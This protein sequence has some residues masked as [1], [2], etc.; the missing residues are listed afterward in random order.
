MSSC[1]RGPAHLLEISSEDS[2]CGKV[3]SVGDGKD[4]KTKDGKDIK[5]ADMTLA[6]DSGAKFDVAVWEDPAI[7]KMAVIP[8]GAGVSLIGCTATRDA[9]DGGF[10]INV[11]KTV[12][13]ITGGDRADALTQMSQSEV[14]GC[15]SLTASS[16]G[17]APTIDMT[18]KEAV[19]VSATALASVP[20][21]GQDFPPDLF[22]QLNRQSVTAP[23]S[24][25]LIVT[26]S[27]DRLWVP[28][29]VSDWT[30]SAS[31][32][33]GN[34]S[35]PTLYDC[36]T[37]DEVHEKAAKGILEVTKSRLNLRGAIRFQDGGV[38]KIVV[39][40]KKSSLTSQISSTSMRMTKGVSQILAEAAQVAPAD[41][42][43]IDDMTGMSVLSDGLGGEKEAIPCIRIFLLVTGTQDTITEPLD[44][45]ALPQDQSFRVT[46]AHAKCL[47]S[48]GDVFVD[49]VGYCNY[50]KMPQFC[51][52]DN[53][54][55]VAISNFEKKEDGRLVVAVEDIQ[56]VSAADVNDVK[57]T[58]D[59][60][61]K[62]ALTKAGGKDLDAYNSPA[63]PEFWSGESARKVCRLDSEPMTPERKKSRM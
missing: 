10:K 56:S 30:G 47:L 26:K 31:V 4:A 27:G 49:L 59:V 40:A 2:V 16:A 14:Q 63:K 44:A 34:S 38:R 3:V 43:E 57:T 23:V 62:T 51:L 15:T 37:S 58:L 29:V 8:Q 45:T 5:V 12:H 24:Q 61:W 39:E 35:A 17:S 9:G 1:P 25:E 48:T 32:H 52:H 60:E 46:S 20:E 53:T 33:F 11:W 41:R 19:A 42:L 7:D 6:D 28:A 54:A 36:A 50:K 22:F 55:F 13:V 21:D 18:G